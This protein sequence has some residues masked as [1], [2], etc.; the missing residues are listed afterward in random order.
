MPEEDHTALEEPD[1]QIDNWE[2]EFAADLEVETELM[3]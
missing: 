1:A 3:Q 2:A